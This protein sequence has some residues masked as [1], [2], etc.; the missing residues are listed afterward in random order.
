M[1]V[2]LDELQQD[3]QQPAQLQS[4]ATPVHVREAGHRAGQ[5]LE[6]AKAL[7]PEGREASDSYHQAGLP[8][9]Q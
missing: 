5:H 4:E 2:N 9:K 3:T 7:C 6:E 1:Q 8:G